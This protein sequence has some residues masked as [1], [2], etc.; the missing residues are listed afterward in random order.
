MADV[1]SPSRTRRAT[2][3]ARHLRDRAPLRVKIVA[4]L[5]LLVTLG[6]LGSGLAGVAIMQTYLVGRVD[7]QLR[8]LADH[9]I[10]DITVAVS[11]GGSSQPDG[12]FDG[13]ARRLPSQFVLEVT[14]SSGAVSYG[15]TSQLLD[16]QEPL[17]ALPRLT[18]AQSQADGTRLITTGAVAGTSQW[19]V[20]ITPVTLIDGTG[21]T[22]LI[23]QGLGDVEE[24]T[25]Q[26]AWLLAAVGGVAVLVIAAVGYLIVRAELRPLQRV[27]QTAAAIA[28]GD[29]GRRVPVLD[30]RT[31]VG[32]LSAAL[33]TMLTE[34]EAAFAQ[35]TASEA[36]AL[37]SEARMRRFVADASH[38]LRTPLTTIR[39]FAEL[40]RQSAV[41]DAQAIQR[42]MGRIEDE[43]A[44][45][46]L[47]V[48]DLL[49]LARLDQQRP[50][51]CSPVDLL[52][53]AADAVFDARA[54]DPSRSIVLEVGTTDPPP[55]V[56]G[57][58]ARLRQVLANLL[59]NALRHTTPG[60]AVTVRIATAMGPPATV[61]LAVDDQGPGLAAEDAERVFER[62]Y[63]TDGSRHRGDGGAGLGLS[64][65]AA[66]VTGHHG[67]V[68]VTSDP[69]A[70]S[71]FVITLPLT[72]GSGG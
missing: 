15:P 1:T 48:D 25:E 44:R 38:E 4:T 5:L 67:T 46:G 60:S 72:D 34:I 7:G 43:A 22:L 2:R 24:T 49:L 52:A 12:D 8:A 56:N 33:N 47:L 66:L 41:A 6:L 36:S 10:A 40:F 54:V 55:I 28:G 27:E 30:P 21:G 37:Q 42:L 70:G 14:D 50:L 13:D 3:R 59:G 11:G 17:P 51:D 71:S 32:Q 23:A 61:C 31:E 62:F 45:M 69:A 39:G 26:L 9:P 64:I 57:D 18:S 63:R 19:R 65:V 16:R 53:L 35:R 58:E 29:L 68:A 20:L